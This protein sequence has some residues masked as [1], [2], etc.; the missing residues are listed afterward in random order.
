MLAAIRAARLSNTFET[1]IDWQGDIDREFAAALA[2]RASQ[3]V[4]VHVLLAWVGSAI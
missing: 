2:E 1:Y 3:G 4:K